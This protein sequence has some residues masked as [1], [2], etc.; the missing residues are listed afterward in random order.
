[1]SHH[2]TQ[3]LEPDPGLYLAACEEV[4]RAVEGQPTDACPSLQFVP[5]ELADVIGVERFAGPCR[6]DEV[7][8]M[9][10]HPG[11]KNGCERV[12][13]V[14]AARARGALGYPHPATFISTEMYLYHTGRK[15]DV[16]TTETTGFRNAYARVNQR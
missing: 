5:A 8:V 14:N 1:M 11:L 3:L 7:V 12:G 6:E 10:L 13:Y 16:S 9:R 15:V 4:A 2:R